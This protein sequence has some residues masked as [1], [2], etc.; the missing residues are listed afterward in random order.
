[1]LRCTKRTWIKN[2]MVNINYRDL[3]NVYMLQNLN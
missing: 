2:V 1:M 3:E